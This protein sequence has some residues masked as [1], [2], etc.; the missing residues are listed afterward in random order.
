MRKLISFL[1]FA[2]APLLAQQADDPPARVARI[3][4]MSGSVSFRPGSVEEWTAATL[5]YPLTIGD[6]LWADSDSR[7]EIHAGSTA[8][9][10]SARTAMS[11]LNLDDRTVQLRFTDGSL[12][13]RLRNLE[14]DESFEI[15]TPNAAITLLRAGEYRIDA[16]GD[17]GTTTVTVRTGNAEVTGGGTAFVVRPRQTGRITGVD[18]AQH[19]VDR[20]LPYNEFDYWSEARDRKEDEASVSAQYVPRDMVGYEDL[21]VNGVWTETPDYGPVWRPRTVA[22]D[23][24]P[25]RY[26]HWA[27]VDPWGWTWIDDAPWGFAPF[28]YGRWVIIGG[29][30][31][32][33]PGR[34]VVGARPVYAPALVVF[35]G[36]PGYR[37]AAWFPLGPREVYRPVYRSSDYYLLR[38][39]VTQVT[40]VTV[41]NN[42]YI[43]QRARGAI[44][45]VSHDT[46]VGAR[47]I[48][49]DAARFD[50]REFGRATVIGSAPPVAP[51]R[52]SVLGRS[53]P[54][55]AAPPAR[56][57]DRTVVARR[58]PP[59]APVAFESRR[60]AIEANQGRPQDRGEMER[61][62]GAAPR[63]SRV[64][65]AAPV[66]APPVNT[67]PVNAP[68]PEPRPAIV[69]PSAPDRPI[70]VPRDER[71]GLRRPSTSVEQP[72]PNQPAPRPREDRPV[73]R[74]PAPVVQPPPQTAPA[75]AA[76]SREM[77]RPAPQAAPPQQPAQP[78]APPRDIRRQS[79][80]VEQPKVEPPPSAPP[81]ERRRMERPQRSEQPPAASPRAERPAPEQQQ[82]ARPE[83]N[84]ERPQDRRNNRR[85]E[86]KD[87]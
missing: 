52:V 34:M 55:P 87:Q 75:P 5:N 83:R 50:D 63:A 80:P 78:A 28:H 81:P 39:N 32:W 45:A 12:H 15:D 71:P 9:R 29:G 60:A 61:Y 30:W 57:V 25:Y 43:N 68:P 3:N 54:A 85:P 66:T 59:A 1:L 24:A 37:G 31:V 8:I 51:G 62:R 16:D 53:G 70:A 11:V 46:F 48:G 23:W 36:T 84:D 47:H 40:N 7:V 77:R 22:I 14:D 33:A 67:A 44:T 42:V 72:Q 82:Q 10:M 41:V 4:Y 65:M 35:I 27:W 21:D 6:H 38:V 18:S 73:F 49:R 19:D 79:P 58:A 76:P 13:I 86:K 20:E 74:A 26:G 64:R 56:V 17:A 69:Q 2:A